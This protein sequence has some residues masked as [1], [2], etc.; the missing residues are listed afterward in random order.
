M[1]VLGLKFKFKPD[2][3]TG[4]IEYSYDWTERGYYFE[5]V[6]SEYNCVEAQIFLRCTSKRCW[7]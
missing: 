5:K 7:K 6:R 4:W 1:N 3:S 2:Y